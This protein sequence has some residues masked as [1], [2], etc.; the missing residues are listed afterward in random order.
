MLCELKIGEIMKVLNMRKH[1]SGEKPD[2]KNQ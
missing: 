1:Y 2:A